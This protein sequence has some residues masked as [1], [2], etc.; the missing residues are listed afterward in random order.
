MLC[1]MAVV[2]LYARKVV[3]F[4]RHKKNYLNSGGAFNFT[5]YM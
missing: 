1:F 3:E 2:C 5:N 4:N